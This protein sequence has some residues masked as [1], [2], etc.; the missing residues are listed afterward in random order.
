VIRGVSGR[1]VRGQ[2]L[3]LQHAGVPD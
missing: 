1:E 3:R 2:R